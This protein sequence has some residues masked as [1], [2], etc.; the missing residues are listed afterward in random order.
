MG[1]GPVRRPTPPVLRALDLQ[2]RDRRPLL[3]DQ[4]PDQDYYYR[5]DQFSFARIGVPGIYLDGGVDI[6][7]KPD[8]WGTQQIDLYTT[9]DYH[10]PSDELGDDWV[11]DGMVADTRF[12]LLTTY[13]IAQANEMQ[14][15]NP[16]DEFAAARAA[17]LSALEESAASTPSAD[18]TN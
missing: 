14:S 2:V 5:S 18:Q 1:P 13:L 11:F 17:A 4:F 7:G 6:I 16:G 10:Q 8:G 12:G 15:W 9:R 3:G